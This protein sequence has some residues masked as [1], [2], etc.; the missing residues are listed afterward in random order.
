[1]LRNLLLLASAATAAASDGLSIQAQLVKTG[2]FVLS[3][4]G[5]NAVL[6]LSGNGFIL[7]DGE[8]AGDYEAL[9]KKIEKISFS[10]QPVRAVILTD[11]CQ[12][13]TGNNTK[14][15]EDGTR[16]LAHANALRNVA[17]LKF[18]AITYQSD[19][20]LHLGGVDV[21]L[22]HFGN[23][24]TN[25]DTVVYFP[26]L[27]V[28]AVGGLYAESPRPDYAAGGSLV[29]WS[30]ALADVLKLD[31]DVAVPGAGPGVSRAGIEQF[32]VR[33]DTLL[34][35]ARTLVKQG[36]S[37]DRFRSQ[38]ALD[39]LGRRFSPEELDHLYSEFTR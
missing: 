6:R 17:E 1:M 21:Q 18:P 20:Q 27:K 22:F 12:L 32:K 9:L 16:I 35:R 11:H 13:E 15:L 14:F 33:L 31:F 7:V 25:G 37:H 5:R 19:Y 23:A 24:R 39:D 28:V 38:L 3:S 26:V 29:G 10:D 2:L 30:A 4:G 36:A 8:R 34:S